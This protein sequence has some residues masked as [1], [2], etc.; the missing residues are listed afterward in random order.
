VW[1]AA[2]LSLYFI[3]F[4]IYVAPYLALMPEIAWTPRERVDLSTL[5]AAVGLPVA[6]FGFVWA[7][8]IDWGRDAGLDTAASVRAIV[9]VS[10]LVALGLCVLPILAVDE[11]RHCRT[12]P[13]GLSLTDALRRTLSNV[14]FRR[15]I[16][17][18]IPFIVGVNLISPALVYYATVVL[19]R[20][21]GYILYLGGALLV[22]TL[23][24]FVPVNLFARR[25][26]PKR[27]IVLCTAWLTVTVAV[28]GLLRPDV[29]GGPN[30]GWNLFVAYAAMIGTGIPLAGFSTMPNVLIA[31]VVDYDAART[32]AQRA[33]IYFGVQGLVTKFLYGISSAILAFLFA[34][35]GNSVAD[36]HGVLLVGPVAA[37]FCLASVFLFMRYPEKEVLAARLAD[38]ETEVKP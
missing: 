20:S 10:S 17:A 18:Q 3:F 28:L 2:L 8:G 31:Q 1:L 11:A 24:G 30:D 7:T 19:V 12:V 6:V 23:V 25:A 27:T 4:T 33:A 13:A 21:E 14:P 36:P 15:Y 38:G 16:A 37:A 22:S 9:V 34:R 32:G 5:M 35:F 29:P 26:G